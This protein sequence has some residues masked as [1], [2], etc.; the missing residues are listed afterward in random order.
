MH[1]ADCMNRDIC[2]QI[3]KQRGVSCTVWP[4]EAVVTQCVSSCFSV[5]VFLSF[6]VVGE[7]LALFVYL[8]IALK[9]FPPL[10]GESMHRACKRNCQ[11]TKTADLKTLCQH[12]W[13]QPLKTAICLCMAWAQN[14]DF[15]TLQ[16][17][18]LLPALP[19]MYFVTWGKSD[20]SLSLSSQ[21]ASLSHGDISCLTKT[22]RINCPTFEVINCHEGPDP[23]PVHK[24]RFYHCFW[25]EENYDPSAYKWA[26]PTVT[27]QV[28]S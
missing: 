27:V 2:S 7:Q 26:N 17:S 20:L 28:D 5:I 6:L 8:I 12:G 11:D 9:L 22:G 4:R 14:W 21:R 13:Q 25:R 23:A 15:C 10:P 18:E 1:V 3:S 16:F 19:R 24:E